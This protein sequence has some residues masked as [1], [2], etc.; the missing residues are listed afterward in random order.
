MISLTGRTA[1]VSPEIVSTI[2][3]LLSS[4]YHR[5]LKSPFTASALFTV[6][7]LLCCCSTAARASDPPFDLKQARTEIEEVNR[8]YCEVMRKGD[9]AGLARFFTLDAKSMGPNEPAHE[10]RAKIEDFRPG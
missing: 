4:A 10:G 5:R 2:D 6:F 9:A 3:G 7:I 8:R 1:V